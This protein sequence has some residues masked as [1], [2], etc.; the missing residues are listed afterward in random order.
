MPRRLKLNRKKGDSNNDHGLNNF[1][2]NSVKATEIV[3]KHSVSR[4]HITIFNALH[5][6]AKEYMQQIKNYGLVRHQWF[7]RWLLNKCIA[8]ILY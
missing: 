2:F 8:R 7:M 6:R 1:N 4:S 5:H 3:I